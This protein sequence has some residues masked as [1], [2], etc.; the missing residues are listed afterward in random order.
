MTK[1]QGRRATAGAYLLNIVYVYDDYYR[2]RGGI[3]NNL[4][5]LAEAFARRGH[6]VTVLV[7][8]PG[9]HTVEEDLNGVHVIRAGRLATVASTPLSLSFPRQLHALQPDLT[10]LHLPYPVGE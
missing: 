2:V 5:D 4:R 3:G 6:Q 10:H 7:T 9:R 8:H 1:D